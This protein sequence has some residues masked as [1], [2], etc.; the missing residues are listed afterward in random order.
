V[1]NGVEVV[2]VDRYRVRD[3]AVYADY[4]VEIQDTAI[5][6]FY[7]YDPMT[8]APGASLE[9]HVWKNDRSDFTTIKFDKDFQDRIWQ[10][11]KGWADLAKVSK[12]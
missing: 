10:M 12:G 4:N 11:F 5:A 8:F 9:L 7:S 3:T 6:G 1:R 2:P